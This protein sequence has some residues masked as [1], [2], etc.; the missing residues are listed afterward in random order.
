VVGNKLKTKDDGEVIPASSVAWTT[1]YTTPALSSFSVSPGNTSITAAV[2]PNV[3]GKVYAIV[4]PAGS[5]APSAAQIAAGQNSG[6][7]PALAAAKNENVSASASVTLPVMSGLVSGNAYDVWA[8]LYSNASGTYSAPVKQTA[9]TTLPQI[10]LN[11]LTVKPI[12]DGTVKGDQISFNPTTY[13]YSVELNT[14]ISTVELQAQGDSAA[15]I[16][17]TGNGLGTVTGTGSVNATVDIAAN[18]SLSI[19]ISSAGSTS[20]T[21]TVSLGSADDTSLKVIRI[22]GNSPTVGAG[23]FSYAMAT[24]GSAIIT[25]E[26]ETNDDFAE[27]EAPSGIGV[28]VQETLSGLG[29]ASFSLT[30]P[31]GSDP[32]AVE[33][34]VRSGSAATSYYITFTRP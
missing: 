9:T 33:F 32:V 15:T 13:H 14:S 24:S 34:N 26:V 28:D 22:N 27:I 3:A 4:V 17:L 31:E 20:S 25:L 5:P 11:D 30:F 6:G 29:N 18:P 19:T 2:T 23:D 8:A 1:G 16:T 12:V 10:A 7:T 21:Y